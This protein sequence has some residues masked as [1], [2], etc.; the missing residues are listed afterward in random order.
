MRGAPGTAASPV[1]RPQARAGRTEGRQDAGGSGPAR[2]EPAHPV[3][4][5]PTGV[6]G[7]PHAPGVAVNAQ[8]K[9]RIS[10]QLFNFGC[11]LSHKTGQ[12]LTLCTEWA[13][14]CDSV[15]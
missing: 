2:A 15:A 12:L 6:S 1:P 13:P 9:R 3:R 10:P 11:D 4:P 8:E 14:R 7:R 5:S